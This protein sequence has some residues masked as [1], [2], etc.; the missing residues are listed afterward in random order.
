MRGQIKP[1]E[2]T[3]REE[4]TEFCVQCRPKVIRLLREILKQL[5]GE[6]DE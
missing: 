6:A 2:G 4:S 1:R 5:R 3:G